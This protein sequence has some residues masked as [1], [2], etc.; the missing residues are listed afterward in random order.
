M[1]K[2]SFS[3]ILLALAHGA[4]SAAPATANGSGALALAALVAARSPALSWHKRNVMAHL[5]EGRLHFF[6]HANQ[7]IMV[8]A[9]GVLCRAGNVDISAHSCT[10]T[11]G[12][13]TRTLNGRRAHELFAT[14]AENG[15]PADGAAGSV[16]EALGQLEC[17]IDPN[18]IKQKAGGG[19][20]CAFVPGAP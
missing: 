7:K 18:E 14:I 15:V 1:K 5:L 4:A 17:M 12:S 11:F 10:L 16:F 8:K 13:H 2:L 3:I 20:S 9:D 6:F 19:A